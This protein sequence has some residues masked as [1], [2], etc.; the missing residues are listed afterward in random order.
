M[1]DAISG[2]RGDAGL[3]CL[4]VTFEACSVAGV[5]GW[6]EAYRVVMLDFSSL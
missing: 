1:A 2:F 3:S 4:V 5:A 6:S